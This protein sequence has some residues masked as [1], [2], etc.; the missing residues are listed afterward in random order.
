[1]VERFFASITED[2]IRRGI[3]KSVTDLEAAIADY[4]TK[5]NATSKPIRVDQVSGRHPPQG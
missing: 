2:A 5:H 4:L 1:L 3:F